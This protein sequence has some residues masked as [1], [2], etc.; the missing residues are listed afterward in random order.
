MTD[1]DVA[2]VGSGPNGLSAAVTL[3]RAG[4]SVIVYEAADTIGG[5]ARTAALTLPGFQHDVCSAVHPQALA[6]PFF[7]AFEL[8]KRVQFAVPEL[9]YAH[10]LDGARAGFAY[11]DLD[12]TA[13]ALGADG[14]AWVRMVRPLLDRLDGVIDFT[15]GPMLRMP[16]HP[17]AVADFGLRALWQGTRCWNLGFRGEIAPA[18]F[19]GVAAHAGG[20]LP[21]LGSAGAGLLLAAHAHAAGW[22]VPIGGSQSI[23]DVMA[24]D[25]RAHGGRIVTG[26]P[27][28]KLGD[29]ASATAVLFDTSP[30]E[31]VRIVGARVPDRYR[32][33]AERFRYGSAVAKVDFALNGPV[34]WTNEEV[35]GA[36]TVH[37]GGARAQ[38]ADAEFQVR[39]GRHPERPYV[40][41]SQPSV[42]DPSRAPAG[43]QALWAYMHVPLGS[44]LDPT[45]TITAQI[46]RSAPGFREVIL[47]SSARSAV[48]V[49][50]YN[51]NYVGGDISGGEVSI[52][53]LMRRPVLSGHP[54]VTPIRGTYLCS[55]STP[56]GPS[57]HGMGGWFAAIAALERSFGI[58]EPP[59]LELEA[60]AR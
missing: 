30:R 40:L 4:L 18:M 21:S 10:P 60:A 46:E 5:G 7:R 57:V 56:P 29:I 24:A 41:L 37:L 35:A 47:A 54:W 15:G 2:I 31:M 16:R 1:V 55:A 42:F 36:G 26:A 8:Q 43:R 38:I 48:G 25:I 14:R 32:Q 51:P 52:A 19:A 12:R 44:D 34:P 33:R 39:A 45:E 20:R 53:Q 11:R 28:Q 22:P 23:V 13:D 3:A 50:A 58:S 27:V 9:S 6:S 17:I 49:E 59:A